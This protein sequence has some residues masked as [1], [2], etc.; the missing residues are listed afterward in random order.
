MYSLQDDRTSLNIILS[1]CFFLADTHLFVSA[2]G[3]DLLQESA[4]KS[5]L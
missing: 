4:V 5:S 2:K 1:Y 3:Y